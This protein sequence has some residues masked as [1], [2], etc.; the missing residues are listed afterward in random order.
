MYTLTTACYTDICSQPVDHGPCQ[1][2]LARW[3]YSATDSRCHQF[4]YG[5]CEGNRNRFMT[6]DLCMQQCGYLSGEPV[7]TES[8]VESSLVS[9]SSGTLH[10]L[11]SSKNAFSDFSL[12]SKFNIRW[13][14]FCILSQ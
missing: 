1:K 4:P 7:Y 3:Y 11:K 6:E 8:H 10:T 9:G 5:G 12:H 13:L 14:A 2:S